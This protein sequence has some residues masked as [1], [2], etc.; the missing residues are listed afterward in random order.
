[1]TDFLVN[2]FAISS[3]AR[4]PIY[5]SINELHVSLYGKLWLEQ[6]LQ[7]EPSFYTENKPGV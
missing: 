5:Q 6:N 4:V 7:M 3:D 1:M 2:W